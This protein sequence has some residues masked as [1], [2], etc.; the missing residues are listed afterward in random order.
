VADTIGEL[1]LFYALVPPLS[2]AFARRSQRTERSADQARAAVL[3][4]NWQ[5]F[6]DSYAALLRAGG[7]KQVTD[8]ASLA[9]AVLDLIQ[10]ES[11]RK[12]MTERA[13]LTIASMS[14]ALPRTLAELENY[15]PPKT[16]LKHAS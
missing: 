8:A 2:S 16:T 13:L 15:L 11:V 10:D 9:E 12:T 3:G 14:G 1:G 7:C 5:N 6:R 4:P